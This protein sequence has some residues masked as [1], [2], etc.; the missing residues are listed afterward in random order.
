[1][2]KHLKNDINLDNKYGKI[3]SRQGLRLVYLENRVKEVED[4]LIQERIDCIE[5]LQ[6]LIYI[7]RNPNNNLQDILNAV[8]GTLELITGGIIKKKKELRKIS[9]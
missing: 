6:S 3:I 4:Q 9:F 1:M 8:T 2:A 5:D 7:A